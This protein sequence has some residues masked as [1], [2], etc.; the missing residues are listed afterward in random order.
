[1]LSVYHSAW[2]VKETLLTIQAILG[3]NDR[4]CQLSHR[5]GLFCLLC[6]HQQ[7]TAEMCHHYREDYIPDRQ[8][9][10]PPLLSE[11]D[12]TDRPSWRRVPQHLHRSSI[13]HANL[14]E[15]A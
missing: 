4:M 9:C 14:E 7:E 5:C 12:V 10:E 3:R 2:T 8:S 11:R 6:L 13:Q 1:M 15:S